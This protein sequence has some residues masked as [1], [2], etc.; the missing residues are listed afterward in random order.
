MT[1]KFRVKAS[2]NAEGARGLMKEGGTARRAALQKVIESLGGKMEGFCFAYGEHDAYVIAEFSDPSA[3]LAV[4]E[5]FSELG[6]IARERTRHPVPEWVL[7][8]VFAALAGPKRLII[9]PRAQHNPSL[10]DSSVW[11]EVEWWVQDLLRSMPG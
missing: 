6:T 9:V 1:P 3:G 2:Y 10:R 8:R 7:R 11:T 5:V 4:R